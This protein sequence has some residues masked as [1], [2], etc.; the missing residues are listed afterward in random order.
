VKKFLRFSLYSILF[1]AATAALYLQLSISGFFQIQQVKVYIENDES[2]QFSSL[3]AFEKINKEADKMRG[4][5]LYKV[6]L[7]GLQI[8]LRQEG[9]IRSFQIARRWPA[10]LEIRI[11]P[12]TV[13]FSIL[14]DKGKLLP[15]IESGKILDEVSVARAPLAPLTR[16]KEFINN[17]ELRV[18]AVQLFKNIPLQGEFSRKSISEIE[19]DKSRGFVLTLTDGSISVK[20]GENNVRQKSLQI[21]QV[22][23]YLKERQFQARVIDANLSQKV[24]VR[25]RKDP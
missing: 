17:D 22:M 20:L 14:N 1:V 5:D 4:Q 13:Y 16:Q 2:S 21:T 8:Q 15:V 19:F 24:L 23:H 10:Q 6:D 12:Q 18:R 3:S 9:W 7:S 11:R 25:L